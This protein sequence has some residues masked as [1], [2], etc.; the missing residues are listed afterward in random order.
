MLRSC[1]ITCASLGWKF[2]CGP[3]T[4]R[5]TPTDFRSPASPCTS[6]AMKYRVDLDTQTNK[7]PRRTPTSG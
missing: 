2:D 7:P 1:V 6:N 5:T 4:V 3:A